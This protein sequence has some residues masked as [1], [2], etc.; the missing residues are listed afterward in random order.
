MAFSTF[1]LLICRINESILHFHLESLT[2]PS[3]SRAQKNSLFPQWLI[4]KINRFIHFLMCSKSSRSHMHSYIQ[5]MHVY[6]DGYK[7][8]DNT[9]CKHDTNKY[10]QVHLCHCFCRL[11]FF[12]DFFF[13]R[14][15]FLKLQIYMNMQTLCLEP[16]P[17]MPHSIFNGNNFFFFFFFKSNNNNDNNNKWNN[18][19]FLD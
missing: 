13:E 5:Q 11:W 3:F 1:V 7:T 2:G 14:C 18:L 4:R 16:R 10:F 17:V 19:S 6:C 8:V 12:L 15:F 9:C